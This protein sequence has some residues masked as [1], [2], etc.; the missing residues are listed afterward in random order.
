VSVVGDAPGVRPGMAEIAL[1]PLGMREFQLEVSEG[2]RQ[3]ERR[4]AVPVTLGEGVELPAGDLERVVRESVRFL[5]ER[6]P[7]SSIL[8]RFSL[9]DITS[10]S[11]EYPGELAH[12]LR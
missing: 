1:N 4:V 6:E 5:L 2:G 3:T 8:S 9:T 12:R 11:P 7:A 10:Y